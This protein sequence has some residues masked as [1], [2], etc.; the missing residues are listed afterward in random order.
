MVA[1]TKTHKESVVS[2]FHAVMSATNAN[3]KQPITPT[4]TGNTNC[5]FNV[6]DV[7]FLHE[8]AGPIPV[9]PSKSKP[10]GT[11]HKLKNCGPTLTSRCVTYLKIEGNNVANVT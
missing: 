6:S 3:N 4:T 8:S 9:I 10:I 2:G 5:D 7:D 11:I 1:V